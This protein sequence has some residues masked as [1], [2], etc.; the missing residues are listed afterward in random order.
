[1]GRMTLLLGILPACFLTHT[2]QS[3]EFN[4]HHHD[5]STQT[6][7]SWSQT[8][9]GVQ[10]VITGSDDLY[11]TEQGMGI[12]DDHAKGELDAKKG[13]Q[14][15]LVF[16]FY[17]AENQPLNVVIKRLRVKMFE[18]K[19]SQDKATII[20]LDGKE[21]ASLNASMDYSSSAGFGEDRHVGQSW[22]LQESV[23]VFS[24]FTLRPEK[25]A[26]FYVYDLDVEAM[27]MPPVFKSKPITVTAEGQPYL[28]PLDV[29]DENP[30]ELSLALIEG[31]D[32]MYLDPEK[33]QLTW[34]P[35][36]ESQGLYPVLVVATDKEGQET[37][38]KFNIEV[39]NRNQPPL[40]TSTPLLKAKETQR[41]QYKISTLDKDQDEVFIKILEAPIG[42][43]YDEKTKILSWQPDFNHAGD[44]FIKLGAS[45]VFDETQQSFTIHVADTN[46]LPTI[47][48][49]AIDEVAEGQSYVYHLSATDPDQDQLTYKLVHGPDQLAVDAVTGKVMWQPDY[50]QA[51]VHKVSVQVDDGK[52]GMAQ[53]TFDIEVKNVN[54]LP[55]F[56][57]MPVDK[58]EENQFYRYRLQAKDADL[59]GLSFALE[60]GPSGMALNETVNSLQ[61]QPDFNDAGMHDV[62]VSVS[63][64]EDKVEQAFK[65]QVTDFNRL[66]V[67][68]PIASQRL[69]EGELLEVEIEATDMDDHEVTYEL[70]QAPAQLALNPKTGAI[71]WTP[72]FNQ[73]GQHQIWVRA[74]DE[75]GGIAESFFNISV[76]NVNRAPQI[77]SRANTVAQ[78]TQRY[79]Y[80]IQ[81][82]DADQDS[83]SY[84]LVAGPKGMKL[85]AKHGYL[86]WQPDYSHA[87]EH[88]ITV[89]ITDGFT[90]VQQSFKLT[91]ANQNRLPQWA[92]SPVTQAS[93]TQAYRYQLAVT[94]ADKDNL[95]FELVSGPAGM[96]LDEKTQTLHW[97]PTYEQSGLHNVSLRVTDGH[98]GQ[99][100]QRFT[101]D[102][103]N[104]NRPPQWISKAE[105]SVKEN[106]LYRYQ[107]TAEDADGDR[108]RYK[109]VSAHKG[110]TLDPYSHTLT[111]QTGFRSAGRH[112]VKLSVTDGKAVV[113]QRFTLAVHDQNRS[114]KINSVAPNL[115]KEGM[116]YEYQVAASDLDTD[117]LSYNL[118]QAPAGMSIESSTGLIQW[119]VQYE[120]AGQ[121]GVEIEVSDEKGESVR[122]TIALRVEN[123]NRMPEF[124]SK[125]DTS[126]QLGKPFRYRLQ[127]EDAD[128][129]DLTFRLLSAP[130]GMVLDRDTQT[131]HWSG[132]S[133]KQGRF[134]VVVELSDGEAKQQQ[135]FALNVLSPSAIA[136]SDL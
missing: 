63:D 99:A 8:N 86:T 103:K 40:F 15:T 113:E 31:P 30:T 127:A 90:R 111:W 45:D 35:G 58:I 95:F 93:E 52:R 64:G 55:E 135:R 54:R 133:V 56:V 34:T 75:L 128:W 46:R 9:A 129:N 100:Q 110:F 29:R 131:L 28:Y 102:V 97:T 120:D 11:L 126:I 115:V 130:E 65:V 94:D 4:F 68:Q 10:L 13:N 17:D 112:D 59:T 1:M 101:V 57:S 12:E 109:L 81:A 116:L 85:D 53:Q 104:K 16:K 84:I 60:D 37:P 20:Q 132:S 69:K 24:G 83:L 7:R 78:E 87:G 136:T 27:D 134:D 98:S 123:V 43:E 114:P 32:G 107:L 72:E 33:S 2:V 74:L 70:L 80:H 71:R 91:V 79:F 88:P 121:H 39:S 18:P 50:L 125:P 25:N 117:E 5:Q 42:M 73:A 77:T 67:W 41:Y 96:S 22:S 19:V 51:G 6:Q 36:F 105:T 92:S 82:Q 23:E 14:D 62:V 44:H 21:L 106:R 38:H 66:P 49:H 119:Q 124:I 89:E 122:Q 26:G 118:I 3:A 61:W 47:T 76:A 108:L 48:S